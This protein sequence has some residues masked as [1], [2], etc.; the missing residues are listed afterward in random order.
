MVASLRVRSFLYLWL[1]MLAMMAS[2]QMQMLARGYL[3]YEITGSKTLLGLVSAAPAVPILALSLIGGAFAD[4]LDRK[5]II[6]VAQLVSAAGALAVGIAIT[7]GVVAWP[8]LLAVGVSQGALWA[9]LMPARQAVIPE[10]VGAAA[11]GERGGPERRGHE[12][13]DA[14]L[15]RRRRYPLRPAGS[16]VRLLHEWG[17][18]DCRSLLHDPDA[19]HQ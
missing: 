7:T 9:F 18:C 14:G 5:R 1:G 13:H 19:A 8:H 12:C 15:A 6:Q 2:V 16:R 17:A 10:L 4:R 11:D 3:A